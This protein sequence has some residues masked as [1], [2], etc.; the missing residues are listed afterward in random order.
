MQEWKA[1]LQQICMY[2]KDFQ[3]YEYKTSTGE[4]D[5]EIMGIMKIKTFFAGW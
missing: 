1:I 2:N 3:P 4:T 5:Y